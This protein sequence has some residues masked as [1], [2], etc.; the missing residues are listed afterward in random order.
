MRKMVVSNNI[1]ME[2]LLDFVQVWEEQGR[3]RQFQTIIIANFSDI[4]IR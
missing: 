1:S 2:N 4:L 3:E